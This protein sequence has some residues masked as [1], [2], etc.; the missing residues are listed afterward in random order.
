MIMVHFWSPWLFC[1]IHVHSEAVD[2]FY[3]HPKYHKSS[4]YCMAW[5]ND[6]VLASGS[7][8]QTIRLLTCSP[9][10]KF[11]VQKPLILHKGTVRDLAFTKEG[12]LVSG[13][14]GSLHVK[15]TDLNTRQTVL[16]LAGHTD[17][18]LALGVLPGG[19]VV[20]GG[21][22]NKV[23][24]WDMRTHLP[25]TS[26]SLGSSVTS[27][28]VCREGL[29]TAHLDGSCSV[30]ELK[31]YQCTASYM[32]HSGE[33]RTVRFCPDKAKTSWVLSGSYDGTVCLAEVAAAAERVQWTKLCQHKDKVIQCRWHPE[34]HLFAS[35]GA[36]RKAC[37]W[38]IH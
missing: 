1:F 36:D 28:T 20:S 25:T 18:I 7:N 5:L 27:L 11:K 32:P 9:D 2:T 10:H 35:T 15:V 8:D 29:V 13:G 37:F 16:S 19:L 3:R 22:D 38:R 23:L 14:G 17:Q 4:I 26:I 31:S 6:T 12:L 33:C 21:Q 34:G 24:I 30:H